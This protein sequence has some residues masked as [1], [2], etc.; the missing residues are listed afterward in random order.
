MKQS[1]KIKIAIAFLLFLALIQPAIA[2]AQKVILFSWDGVQKNHLFEMLANGELQNLSRIKSEGIIRDLTIYDHFNT[3]TAPGHAELLSGYGEAKNGVKNNGDSLLD[4]ISIFEKLECY[5]S[6]IATGAIFG[7]NRPH[8]P[9]ALMK[10]ASIDIDW[11]LDL[12][13]WSGWEGYTSNHS[14]AHSIASKAN[15]FIDSNKDKSFFLFIHFTDPDTQGHSYGENSQ[16]YSNAI[17]EA[18]IGLGIVILELEKLGIYHQVIIIV[19]TDHGFNEDSKTHN[20]NIDTRELWIASNKGNAISRGVLVEQSSITPTILE[21]FNINI[22]PYD[23]DGESLYSKET[24]QVIPEYP[25]LALPIVAI[26]AL[27]LFASHVKRKQR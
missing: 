5:D 9:A 26:I 2:S 17:K 21:I 3:E 8:F 1:R 18:D 24:A 12:D 7:K 25:S 4:G 11:Y 6:N 14:Y 19:T 15:E 20:P 22:A 23:Y 13:H 16:E 10:N 27:I